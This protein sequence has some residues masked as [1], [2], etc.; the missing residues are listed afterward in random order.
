MSL[1]SIYKPVKEEL[2]LIEESLASIARTGFVWLTEILQYTLKGGGKRIRPALVLLAGKFHKYDMTYLLPM[3]VAVELMHTATLVHDDAIDKS[4]TRRGRATIYKML[5]EE[6][7]VLLGDFLFARAGEAVSDTQNV[8][9]IKLFSQTLERITSGELNQALNAYNLEQTMENYLNR[10]SGKTASLFSLSTTSGAILSWAP[11][12]VVNSLRE[13]GHDL[14]IAFQI[15][16]DTLDF[17]G[18]E[19]ELGKPV[20]S[21]LA[22]GTLTLPAMLSLKL[23]PEDNPVRK[24]FSN[25]GMPASEKQSHIKRA[26][27]LVLNSSI[28]EQCYATATEYSVMAG[29]RVRG[30]PDNASR[31]A[32]F[33]LAEYV[34]SRR[35]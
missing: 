29:D 30:L 9:V 23:Y 13:Y 28:I 34:V 7:A 12:E 21:D 15:A 2:T 32:L 10:I 33:E 17:A 31:R 4:D 11:A 18:T 27:E 1:D 19:E 5:G 14:G 26:I 25:P 24:L 35:K 22:Q 20:G 16:D 6:K 8:G 3:G